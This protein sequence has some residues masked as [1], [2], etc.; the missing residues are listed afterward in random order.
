MQASLVAQWQRIHLPVQK[1]RDS[2]LVQEDPTCKKHLSPCI[3]TTEPVLWSPGTATTRPHT[4]EPGLCND[5]SHH[6]EKSTHHH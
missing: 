2:S 4:I 6:H 1:T 3:I 5:R